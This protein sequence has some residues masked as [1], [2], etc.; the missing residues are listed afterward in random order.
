MEASVRSGDQREIGLISLVQAGVSQ[1]CVSQRCTD[2]AKREFGLG[3]LLFRASRRQ[4]GNYPETGSRKLSTT[5][6]RF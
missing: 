1:P 4:L 6:P 3:E 2:W 5:N